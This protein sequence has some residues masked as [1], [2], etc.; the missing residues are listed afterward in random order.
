MPRSWIFTGE[1]CASRMAASSCPADPAQFRRGKTWWCQPCIALQFRSK[2][3]AKDKGWLAAYFDVLSRIRGKQQ[4]YFTDPARL[5]LFYSGLRAPDPSAP[6]TRG[7][8]RPAPWM[9]LLATRLHLD[10]SGQPLVPGNLQEWNDLIFRQ[11]DS[12]LTRKWARQNFQIKN[13]DELIRMMFA[14]SR[15]PSDATPLQAYMAISELDARRS[16]EHRLAPATVRLMGRKFEE[17]S[18][19]YRVFSEFPGF[20]RSVHRSFSANR[21]R[22]A[23]RC[24]RRPRQR[25]GNF[26]ADVGMW[27]ILARQGEISKFAAERIVAAADQAVR[28]H[29]VGGAG[30]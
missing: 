13:A 6:A 19:Q 17:F 20:R 30:I 23:Q 2:L 26:Q 9:L 8:F 15:A 18:D 14:L 3:L 25:D 10:D 16:P 1:N 11:R 5:Q 12:S 22:A 28:G 24:C 29:P 21:A 4:E 27:Q 7:S